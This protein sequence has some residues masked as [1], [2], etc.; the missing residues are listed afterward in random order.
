MAWLMRDAE[1][2]ASLEIATTRRDRAKGLLGRD[3]LDGA[4]L[5]ERARSVHTFGMRFPIDVAFLDEDLVVV[6][7]TQLRRFRMTMPVRGAHHAL[8]AEA[9][10]FARWDL[11]VGDKLEIQGNDAPPDG[12]GDG[13]SSGA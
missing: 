4:L 8:E 10:A 7:T 5:I 6:R 13:P 3:G 11:V 2:L 12:N 9:G 1:V